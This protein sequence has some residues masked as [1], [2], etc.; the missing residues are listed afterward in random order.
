LNDISGR[1][2]RDITQYP[3]MPWMY[4][5][6]SDEMENGVNNSCNFRDL[7]KNIGS[8]GPQDRLKYFIEKF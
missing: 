6:S 5:N 8:F 1:N 7:T 3:I 4:I 2:Y